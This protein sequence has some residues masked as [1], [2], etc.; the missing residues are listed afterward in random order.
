MCNYINEI[1]LHITSILDAVT[2]FLSSAF[3]HTIIATFAAAFAG[4]Y[5]A[6]Y[7]SERL[8]KKDAVLKEL[9]STNAAIMAS[10]MICNKAL[11]LKKQ[12]VRALKEDYYEDRNNAIT[13]KRGVD[14]GAIASDVVY[15]SEFDLRTLQKVVLPIN[16]LNKQVFESIS[17]NGRALALVITLDGVLEALN[18]SITERNSCIDKL[19]QL[20]LSNNKAAIELYYAFP[21]ADGNVDEIYMN[22]IDAIYKF[23]DDL[24]FFSNLLCDDLNKHGN[25]V[26][27]ILKDDELVVN[28]P[29]MANAEEEGLMPDASEYQDWLTMFNV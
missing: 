12:H 18:T 1:C 7:I 13:H 3:F 10:F 9:R 16:T 29:I 11:S 19:K 26:K 25:K 24:I 6:Q 20:M 27:S 5:G 2:V 28:K 17:A 4:A 23:T 8:R 21:D 14:V 22:C 15:E